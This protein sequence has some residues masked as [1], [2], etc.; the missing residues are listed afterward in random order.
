[1]SEIATEEM[2]GEL[3]KMLTSAFSWRYNLPILRAIRKHLTESDLAHWMDRCHE[4]EVELAE[5]SRRTSDKE[6]E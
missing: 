3:D 2:V 5:V 1:M 6:V 4:L